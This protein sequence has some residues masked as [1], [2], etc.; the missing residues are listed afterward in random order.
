MVDERP[1][2]SLL[3]EILI[4]VLAA[5]LI[6]SILY[7]KKVGDQEEVRTELC[8]FRMSEIFNAELQYLKYNR[9]FNDT[10]SQVVNFIRNDSSYAMYVDSVIAAGLDS[11]VTRLDQF[12]KMEEVILADIPSAAD[13]V[14]IDS[15]VNLQVALKRKSRGLAAYV[16]FVHDR[17]KNLPNTPIEEMKEVYKIVDSKQFTLDMDIV[18]NS[19]ESGNLGVAQ[20]AASDIIDRIDLVKAGFQSVL[21]HLPE[22][23][24]SGLDS[25]FHCPTV[26]KEY[27]L[28]YIDTSVIKYLD[29][30]C[31]LDSTDVEIVESSFMKST[32]GGLDIVNHGKIEKGESSWDSR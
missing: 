9:I 10:L 32:L 2:G 1:K 24:G 19:V 20:K 16:E 23:N 18:K 26:N 6:G 5:L 22:H 13:T 30:F 15:L 14:M 11:I 27:I 8:R 28:V 12:R 29:I 7:P 17:M 3:Y 4:V 25:L 21:K 31:P